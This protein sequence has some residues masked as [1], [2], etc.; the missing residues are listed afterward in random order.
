[1]TNRRQIEVNKILYKNFVENYWVSKG[2]DMVNIQ[3]DEDDNVIYL[4][5]LKPSISN[6][7]YLRVEIKINKIPKKVSLH[8]AVYET[9]TGELKEG[10]VIEHLDSNPSNNHYSNLKQSTQAEN[11]HTSMTQGRF[12]QAEKGE[13]I[14]VYDKLKNVTKCY[15]TIKEFFIDI[16]APTYMIKNGGLS[17]L[18]K[19]NSYKNRFVIEKIGRKGKSQQTTETV[20]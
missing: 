7:G 15:E 1:M 19:R 14:I 2:G 20:M 3:F 4:K 11:I 17:M 5:K 12:S 18:N 6:F 8:R 16:Q 9:W 13:N 10:M